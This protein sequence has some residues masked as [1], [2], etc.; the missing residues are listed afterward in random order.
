ML[1]GGQ[2]GLLEE[3]LNAGGQIGLLEEDVN[4]TRLCFEF[5]VLRFAFFTFSF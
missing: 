5:W 4:V 1:T 3:G 2:I